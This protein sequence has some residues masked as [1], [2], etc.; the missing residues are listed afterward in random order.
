MAN[1]IIYKDFFDPDEI[2]EE[3]KEEAQLT[4]SELQRIVI[5]LSRRV[6]KLERN[7]AKF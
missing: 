3:E 7:H 5:E 4:P 6:A 2:E 1:S